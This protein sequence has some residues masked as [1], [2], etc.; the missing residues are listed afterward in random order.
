MLRAALLSLAVTGA[1]QAEGIARADYAEP[2]TRYDHAVLGDG[3]EYGA[4]ALITDTG[5]RLTLRLPAHRVFEDVAPRLVDLEGDGSAE[6]LVVETDVDLG[7]RV[8]VYGADG[9][10]AADGF[11]GQ[12]HRWK[13]PLGAADLD[14]DGRVEIAYVDRPHLAR[15]L[16]I[17]RREGAR[18][19]PVAR[20]AGVTNHRI[21]QDHVSGGIGPCGAMMLADPDWTRALAV[22]WDGTGFATRDLGPYRGRASL[23]PSRAC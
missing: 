19:V 22:T 3:V 15:T 5:R 4:L 18:L 16:V 2:T 14:G 20:M 9:L 13:A 10:I 8:A 11:V 7:A 17:L 21:G 6:V 1:V 12:P 23:D